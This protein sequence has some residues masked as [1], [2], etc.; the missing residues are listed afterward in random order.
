[1]EHRARLARGELKGHVHRATVKP[2]R[3]NFLRIA[4]ELKSQEYVCARVRKYV[5][6]CC[7]VWC[8]KVVDGWWVV[9]GGRWLYTRVGVGG[10]TVVTQATCGERLFRV[11][12][13]GG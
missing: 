6:V 8:G 10:C 5:C 7:A 4:S 11:Q 9:G 1:M 2:A 12:L 3:E 13:N